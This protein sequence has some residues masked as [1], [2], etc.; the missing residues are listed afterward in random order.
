MFGY[1]F[2]SIHVHFSYIINH[3]T[4]SLL[5]LHL[6]ALEKASRLKLPLVRNDL[7]PLHNEL[8]VDIPKPH[9]QSLFKLLTNVS[10]NSFEHLWQ[11]ILPCGC[12][13]KTGSPSSYLPSIN[14][15]RYKNK[16]DLRNFLHALQGMQT[17]KH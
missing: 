6:R 4:F 17:K 12:C 2:I 9:K 16:H 13:C 7:C 11:A 10:S 14:L 15:S 5:W 1:Q 8:G 3:I